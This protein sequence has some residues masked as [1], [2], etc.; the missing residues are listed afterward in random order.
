MCEA[1]LLSFVAHIRSIGR[2]AE[3]G[4]GRVA[5]L[6]PDDRAPGETRTTSHLFVRQLEPGLENG[7]EPRLVV[8]YGGFDADEEVVGGGLGGRR[9][10]SASRL[11][12]IVVARHRPRGSL[13]PH[14][15]L[16]TTEHSYKGRWKENGSKR[17]L[18]RKTIAKTVRRLL[19]MIAILG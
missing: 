18:E 3:R 13:L 4:R 9:R 2:N 8:V 11:L 14:R 6:F 15:I 1:R 5:R 7:V 12:Q 17:R 19:V 16:L 10:G